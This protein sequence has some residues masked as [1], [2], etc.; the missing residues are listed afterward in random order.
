MHI[1]LDGAST[2]L[3]NRRVTFTEKNGEFYLDFAMAMK[4]P[5]AT[6][7][8]VKVIKGKVRLTQL[9]LSEEA[10]QALVKSYLIYKRSKKYD[11]NH[12]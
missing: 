6:T 8:H 12:N 3:H 1:F 5:E 7:T 11:K 10:L 2:R 4:N 9:K